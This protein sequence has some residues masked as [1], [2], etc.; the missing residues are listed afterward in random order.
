MVARK[1]LDEVLAAAEAMG[2]RLPND[3]AN[4]I[5]DSIEGVIKRKNINIR[6]QSDLDLVINEAL[7]MAKTA[8]IIASRRRNNA[9]RNATIHSK[10]INQVVNSKDP[11][12]T[13]RGVLVGSA[14]KGYY[15]SVDAKS[16]TVIADLQGQLLAGLQREGLLESAQS[17]V[18][19]RDVHMV[20]HHKG[21]DLPKVSEDALKIAEVIKRTNNYALDRKNLA[22]AYITKI[23]NYITRQSHDSSLMRKAGFTKWRDDITPLLDETTFKNVRPKKGVKDAQEE[24]LRD[25]YESLISGVHKRSD[26]Q[27]SI[28]GKKDLIASFQGPS[29]LA[30]SMSQSRVLHFKDG[31]ASYQYSQKYNRRNLHET[32]TD[33]LTYDGR[34]IALME[35]FGTNPRAMIERIVKDIAKKAKSDPVLNAKRK[36]QESAIKREFA[37]LD[38]SLNAVGSGDGIF[39]GADFAS[40]SAGVRMIKGTAILGQMALSSIT[41][42]ASKAAVISSNTERGFFGSFGQALADIFEGLRGPE[43]KEI[44]IRLLVGLEGMNTNILSRH[45]PEDFGPGTLSKM[46]A[47]FYKL[48][49]MRYWNNAGKVGTARILAYD[50]AVSVKKSWKDVNSSFKAMLQRYKISEKEMALFKDVD[51]KAADGREYLFPDLAEDIPVNVLDPYIRDKTGNLNI[52][53]AMRSKMRNELRTKI[54][55]IYMDM[56][57]T[58]IPTPGAKEQAIM[59]LGYAKGTAGGEA[60][61][62][63]MMLKAFP[64]TMMTKGISRQYHTSGFI[65]VTK[66]IAGMSAMGYV[67]M[68]AKDILKGKEPRTIFSNDYMKS[69]AV[70]RDSMIQGGSMGL[71]GDLAF[72]DFSKFRGSFLRAAAGPVLSTAEDVVTIFDKAIKGGD[73]GKD[74]F[75]FATK[76]IPFSNLFYTR[77]ALDYMVLYGLME[78][79]DPGYLNKMERR[80]KKDY[81]QEF[82]F[83]P[84]SSAVRY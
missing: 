41:D 75:K 74:T 6:S 22:G 67:A 16:R 57:D 32:I 84:S 68:S 47:L 29:N 36:G 21:P 45:G 4:S 20:L 33:A 54:G 76:N 13:L 30:K 23:I 82:Y 77:T 58:A 83:P 25:V 81:D 52:T 27:Y 61:R 17:G 71:I 78:T 69:A 1:C 73:F 46:N 51:M 72:G 53:D 50:G 7:E 39:F 65:G 64:I 9:L 10:L 8:K 31:E 43:S 48:T 60:I 40:V 34:S 79:M 15:S 59:N 12:E 55:S 44:G 14:K 56:A 70:I 38:N 28:D 35:E 49:G 3:E 2:M 19:D 26:G 63:I 80:Y 66:M 18:H 24:F 5:L 62:M 42:V 37:Q 11:Y